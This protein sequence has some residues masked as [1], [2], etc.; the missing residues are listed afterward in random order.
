MRA[1]F[2]DVAVVQDGNLISIAHGGNTVRDKNCGAA[3]HYF[4]QMVQNFVFGMRVD[5]GERIIENQDARVA[6]QSSRNSGTLLL[7]TG[8]RDAALTNHGGVAFRKTFD[9]GGNVGRVRRIVNFLVAGG[10]N[11]ERN[12][13]PYV[14]TE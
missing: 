4:P 9:V 11:S 6:D 2:D 13:F 1:E 3:L 10:L 14:V 12:V 8:K 5:A 7:A